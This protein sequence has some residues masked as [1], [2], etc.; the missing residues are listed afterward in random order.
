MDILG[1]QPTTGSLEMPFRKWILNSIK[2]NGSTQNTS[3]R[4]GVTSLILTANPPSSV[5]HRLLKCQALS[6]AKGHIDGG[7]GHV[8]GR[9]HQSVTCL[10]EC[11]QKQTP[12]Y[13]TSYRS[14]G[15]SGKMK[16][17]VIEGNQMEAH[18]AKE[19]EGWGRLAASCRIQTVGFSEVLSGCFF[20]LA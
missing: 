16:H 12:K 4:T 17:S 8:H 1:V 3:V 15:G 7:G 13:H 18:R 11:F 14:W 20:P 9:W 19:G 6:N 2:A 10:K 5:P